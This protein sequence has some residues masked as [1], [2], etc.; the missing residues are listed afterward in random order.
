LNEETSALSKR[1]PESFYSAL[2][3]ALV[4][5]KIDFDKLCPPDDLVARR[6]LEDY[7]AMFV[8]AETVVVPSCCV[9]ADACE[10]EDFQTKAGI[11]AA[12]F[13]GVTIELQPEAMRALIEARTEAQAGDLNITPRDGQEA[14]RRTFGDSLRLWDTRFLPALRYWTKQGRI[15][16]ERAE[17]LRRFQPRKQ[18]RAVLELEAENIFFSKDFSKS[19]FYSIAPPGTS[20]H[21]A[22]LAFDAVEFADERVRRILARHGWFQTVLSDLPHFTFLGIDERDLP[23]RGLRREEWNKQIFWIPNV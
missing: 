2:K 17:Q 15:T 7:G 22:M 23:A 10:T 18:V 21:L 11:K 14:G 12:D 3:E 6:A 20:Q 8:A 1:Q 5:R 9:F 16:P 19:V 13:D 4:G